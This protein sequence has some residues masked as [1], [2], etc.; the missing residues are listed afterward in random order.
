MDS[1]TDVD[2]G[3]EYRRAEDFDAYRERVAAD[4]ATESADS[5]GTDW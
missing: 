2:T 1:H 3:I 5:D 4:L